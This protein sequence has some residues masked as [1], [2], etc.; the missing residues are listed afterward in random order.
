VH[1]TTCER[2]EM[3]DWDRIVDEHGAVVFRLARRILGL[4]SDAEDVF[5]DV[6][7]EI[8]QLRQKQEV[9]NW[10]GLLRRITVHRALDRLRRRRPME[11]LSGE[12]FSPAAA[13][14]QELAVAGELAERL[15]EAIAQLPE[16]QAD[17]FSLRYFDE[18][19]Y[20][21]IAEI[22]GIE[23]GAVSAALHKAR[24]KLQ[25]LLKIEVKGAK[26]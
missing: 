20:E 25:S 22:V 8:F 23:P 9:A 11:P 26:S 13:G 18:C 21:E 6:F 10:G 12:E 17:V 3:S 19:S 15:R 14:P 16:R 2:P 5:Q 7:L 4:D 24:F 1:S